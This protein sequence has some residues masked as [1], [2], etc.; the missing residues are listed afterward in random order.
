MV[1]VSRPSWKVDDQ[2]S[3]LTLTQEQLSGK[4]QCAINNDKIALFLR[5]CQERAG[6]L[7]RFRA[8]LVERPNGCIEWTGTKNHQGYGQMVFRFGGK[9]Y[10]VRAHRAAWALRHGLS[11][12]PSDHTCRN[13]A[14][15]NTDHLEPVTTQENNRRGDSP[16]GINA[17][18]TH[19]PYG[20]A[21]TPGNIMKVQ[22][23]PTDRA[24]REC[25]NRRQ[26]KA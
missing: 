11:S 3:D 10:C 23:R 26:R 25:H 22:T 20:H 17:R 21:L 18:K 14:C 9:A 19:C 5:L 13:R 2:V 4:A 15:S 24:C 6:F 7:E 12:H 1:A 16:V 8:R